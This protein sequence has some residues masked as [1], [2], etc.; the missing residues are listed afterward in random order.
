MRPWTIGLILL[1]ACGHGRDDADSHDVPKPSPTPQI[2]HYE[3]FSVLAV[4]HPNFP[5]DELL[6]ATAP[7]P[8][9]AIAY[10]IKTFGDSYDCISRFIR[11][12]RHR[13][14]LIIRYVEPGPGRR[15][16]LLSGFDLLPRLSVGQLNREIERPN[17]EVL[18][19][20]IEFESRD[21]QSLK[22]L[23]LA[24]TRVVTVLGL[25][26]NF[27]ERSALTVSSLLAH[28]DRAEN[29]HNRASIGLRLERHGNVTVMPG[30]IASEDG[31]CQSDSESRLF[32]SRNKHA[33]AS[34]L[35][36]PE[37][38]GR[39]CRGGMLQP[40]TSF[41]RDRRFSFNSDISRVMR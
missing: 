30:E 41:P 11:Q 5:C 28:T 25:E 33:F 19:A 21:A 39:E 40:P 38:Q 2:A 13:P 15:N 9:P 37:W 17:S 26:D 32:L 31:A 6:K 3:G 24:N 36:R 10:A 20:I 29:P 35:W 1:S 23:L 27:T 8:F 7:L 22:P 18:A 14:H 16:G 4:T 12:S 34:F